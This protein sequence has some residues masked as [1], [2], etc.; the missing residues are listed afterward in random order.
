MSDETNH[1]VIVNKLKLII[2]KNNHNQNIYC[3]PV[4]V[5]S[6]SLENKQTKEGKKLIHIHLW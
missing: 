1:K 2:L 5:F 3:R 4:T 6:V